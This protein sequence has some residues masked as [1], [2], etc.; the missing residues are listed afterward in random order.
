MCASK[1]RPALRIPHALLVAAALWQG[2]KG[3][4][5]PN[6]HRPQVD[7][8]FSIG[9]PG[10]P[11]LYAHRAGRAGRA[12]ALGVVV[13]VVGRRELW[14]VRRVARR[15][16]IDVQVSCTAFICL[17][18]V[19]VRVRARVVQAGGAGVLLLSVVGSVTL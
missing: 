7:A 17:V 19:H 12:G 1:L 8:V 9:C 11:L 14:H 13:S 18:C 10:D 6:C 2:A 4:Q 15:L 16:G 5:L 3:V